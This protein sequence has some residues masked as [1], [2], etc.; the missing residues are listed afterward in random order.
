MGTGPSS[1]G[2]HWIPSKH[3]KVN[4]TLGHNKQCTRHWCTHSRHQQ[5]YCIAAEPCIQHSL[6]ISTIANNTCCAAINQISTADLI[7]CSTA[8]AVGNHADY[9]AELDAMHVTLPAD[10]ALL[11]PISD[12]KPW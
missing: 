5:H 1:T 6:E 11:T 7:E 4:S 8:L 9:K 12:C 10:T 2:C 3:S